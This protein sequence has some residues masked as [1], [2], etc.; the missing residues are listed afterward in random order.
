MAAANPANPTNQPN[1]QLQLQAVPSKGALFDAEDKSSYD[2]D[3]RAF[4][5]GYDDL[6]PLCVAA[7]GVS[8]AATAAP[9]RV[10]CVGCGTGQEV[11]A[12]ARAPRA[13][14]AAPLRVVGVDPARQM[15]AYARKRVERELNAEQ[16][17]GVELINAY[18]HDVPCDAAD[19]AAPKY[20]A[21]DAVTSVLVMH[22]LPDSESGA[23]GSKQS[24]LRGITAR[25]KPNATL[26]LVDACADTTPAPA[27]AAELH[28]LMDVWMAHAQ[29]KGASAALALSKKNNFLSY[30][31]V[32]ATRVIALL[33]AAGFVD[34][35]TLYRG[36]M[37][38]GFRAR[39]VG[40]PAPAPAG[41]AGVAAAVSAAAK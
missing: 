8:A 19:A 27:A 14:G 18:L 34:V 17:A 28:A 31:M 32:P 20:N 13:A 35:Q 11:I 12:L 4:V 1:A 33:H 2:S 38:T 3:V 39:F 37:F 40:A 41:A 26:F 16:R 22:F 6:S 23:A 25:L 9:Q 15:V 36:F 7:L 30:H 29:A 21:F 5:L 10:L 24:Y